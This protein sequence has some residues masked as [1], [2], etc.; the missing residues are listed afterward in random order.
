MNTPSPFPK[1][2]LASVYSMA[3]TSFGKYPALTHCWRCWAAVRFVGVSMVAPGF[4][5]IQS[6]I[7]WVG[8]YAAMRFWSG[9]ASPP[10]LAVAFHIMIGWSPAF[11]ALDSRSS[12]AATVVG[13]SVMPICWASFLL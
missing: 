3:L 5:K 11:L 6:L 10:P 8:P 2:E 7:G 9:N 1:R 13:G 12:N 4:W